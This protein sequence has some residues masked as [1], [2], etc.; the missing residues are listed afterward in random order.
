MI[1]YFFDIIKNKQRPYFEQ[2]FASTYQKSH[3][4]WNILLKVANSGNFDD[5]HTE[6]LHLFYFHQ[7]NLIFVFSRNL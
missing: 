6:S 2:F 1:I 5:Q 3:K 7:W 4:F